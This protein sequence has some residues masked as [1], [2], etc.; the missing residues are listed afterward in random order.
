MNIQVEVKNVYGKQIVYPIC[1]TAQ[2][3]A[4]LANQKSF[5]PSTIITI[6]ALGYSIELVQSK[7]EALCNLLGI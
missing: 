6:R 3:L 7:E 2:L 1:E 4:K 5:T